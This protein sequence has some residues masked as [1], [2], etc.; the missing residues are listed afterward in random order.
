MPNTAMVLHV[1]RTLTLLHGA[2][3]SCNLT[4]PALAAMTRHVLYN[5]EHINRYL[6]DEPAPAAPAPAGPAELL[7]AGASPFF[8]LYASS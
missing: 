2:D 3:L 7:L 4:E 5:E 1:T 8:S 6:P